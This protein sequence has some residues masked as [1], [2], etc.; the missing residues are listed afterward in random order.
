MN[1]QLTEYAVKLREWGEYR[2]RFPVLKVPYAER[3]LDQ[4]LEERGINDL[5][6]RRIMRL[7]VHDLY[8]RT[9]AVAAQFGVQPDDIPSAEVLTYIDRFVR[10]FYQDTHRERYPVGG[11]A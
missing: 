7:G 3:T 4:H 10:A 1:D 6:W 5:H 2:D 9:L 8:P 11:A